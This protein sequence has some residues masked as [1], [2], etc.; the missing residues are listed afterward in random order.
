MF[1]DDDYYVDYGDEIVMP[2]TPKV[3]QNVVL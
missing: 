3:E 1:D 2:K